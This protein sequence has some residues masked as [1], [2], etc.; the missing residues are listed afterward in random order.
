MI[1]DKYKA[2]FRILIALIFLG[3]GI[4]RFIDGDFLGGGIALVAGIAFGLS[5]ILKKG[6]KKE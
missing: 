1:P 2:G 6:G 5:L 4:K 3:V